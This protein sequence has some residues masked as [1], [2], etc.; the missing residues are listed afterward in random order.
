[1]SQYDPPSEPPDDTPLP[2]W[3]GTMIQEDCDDCNGTG[4]IA[5]TDEDGFYYSGKCPECGGTGK[6][7]VEDMPERD[8]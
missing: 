3:G 4:T 6:Q 1:M 2:A 5:G 7:W 8:D